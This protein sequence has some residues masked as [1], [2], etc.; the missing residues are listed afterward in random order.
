MHLC[1]AGCMC[2]PQAI[3]TRQVAVR[4][5]LVLVVAPDGPQPA[6][7]GL[8]CPDKALLLH[9]QAR[10]EIFDATFNFH[11][12]H[13]VSMPYPQFLRF[14]LQVLKRLGHAPAGPAFAVHF[15]INLIVLKTLF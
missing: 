8:L 13:N 2:L 1:V 14:F 10:G 15:H 11:A 3:P 9:P 4:R 6:R 5:W 12:L 7:S